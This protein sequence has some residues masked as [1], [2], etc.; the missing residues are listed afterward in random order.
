ME[1]TTAT[2]VFYC[3]SIIFFTFSV[4]ANRLL[5]IDKYL[6]YSVNKRDGTELRFN[7]VRKKEIID[8]GIDDRVTEE[9]TENSIFKELPVL[10]KHTY[11]SV[12]VNPCN[13]NV[14]DN[15]SFEDTEAPVLSKH[16]YSSCSKSTRPA[17]AGDDNFISE[18]Y[19][20][21]RLHHLAMWKAELKKFALS[22]QQKRKKEQPSSIGNNKDK[23]IMHVDLDS[24]FVSV[25]LKLNP[26]LKG[27]PVAVCHS[28]RS[29]KDGIYCTHYFLSRCY[30]GYPQQIMETTNFQS[31]FLCSS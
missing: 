13:D 25:S 31:Q 26:E 12:P 23:L 22:I 20:H 16:T 1:E 30:R 28:G 17:K 21:S 9:L 29:Q 27:N 10:T 5:S 4:K 11:S 19:S 6:L 14:S 24:F 18:F 7:T 8:S 2:A 15:R 3:N